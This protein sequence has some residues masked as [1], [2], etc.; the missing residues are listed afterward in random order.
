MPIGI[1]IGNNM[2]KKEDTEFAKFENFFKEHG[3][4][5]FSGE[6]THLHYKDARKNSIHYILVD[7]TYFHF[8][9]KGNFIG[10]ESDEIGNFTA[11][12]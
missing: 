1:N 7:Q 8:D 9:A 4:P 3:V 6:N 5:C 10:L 2:T 11:R 12:I